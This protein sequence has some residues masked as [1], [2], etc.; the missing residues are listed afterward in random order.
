MNKCV[1]CTKEAVFFSDY[2]IFEKSASGSFRTLV[3]KV[4]FR[5]IVRYGICRECFNTYLQK[6]NKKYTLRKG[7]WFIV[8]LLLFLVFL[9][10]GIKIAIDGQEPTWLII[11]GFLFPVFILVSAFI[12][13][14]NAKKNLASN[15]EC[16]KEMLFSPERLA[17]I[18]KPCADKNIKIENI[19]IENTFFFLK[20]NGE[21]TQY[22]D[23]LRPENN[24]ELVYG[25]FFAAIEA[26]T[27]GAL[28][29]VA[30]SNLKLV[31]PEEILRVYRTMR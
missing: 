27:V 11:C 3:S 6:N 12:M 19:P 20:P 14:A 5:G 15:A 10:V 4:Q 26:N 16:E 17:D 2:P 25:S 28:R 29:N 13:R 9:D 31:V 18:I 23:N 1:R 7:L 24:G 30:F 22:K 8:L 21:I